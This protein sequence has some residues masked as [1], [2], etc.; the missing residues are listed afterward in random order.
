MDRAAE[1]GSQG[2]TAEADQQF[3]AMR[4][5]TAAMAEGGSS[6][7]ER[8]EPVLAVGQEY[9][10]LPDGYV[11]TISD[12]Q[13][14]VVAK[15]ESD[16][17]IPVGL[18]TPLSDT[19]C[20][21]T[22][23]HGLYVITDTS[24][25]AG[26]DPMY[27]RLPIQAYAGAP[28]NPDGPKRGTVCFVNNN[29]PIA[30]FSEW[31]ETL[32]EH[33]TQWVESEIDRYHATEQVERSQRLLEATFNSPET[34]IGILEPDGT[35]TD[36]NTAAREF[37]HADNGDFTGDLVWETPWWDHDEAMATRCKDAIAQAAVGKRAQFESTH[38]G[39]D[40][41][42]IRTTV[43][44]RPVTS[45]GSVE[46]LIIEAADIT[47]LKRHEE[48]IEFFNSVLRH[49]ILNGMTVVEGRAEL[50][51]ESLTDKNAA[52]AETILDWSHSISRL[53]QKIRRILRI[54][55]D[56]EPVQTTAT[57]LNSLV[58]KSVEKITAA[59][60]DCT[61]QVNMHEHTEVL[62]DPLLGDIVEN[63]FMNAIEHGGPG[64]HIEVE[65]ELTDSSIQLHVAD[66]GPGI[67]PEDRQAIFEK[68]EHRAQSQG[69]GFGLYFVSVMI[70]SYGGSIW[71]EE[72][73]LGGCEFILEFQ[74]A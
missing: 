52:H 70:E 51:S 23:T 11:T 34:Y 54:I 21:H 57:E 20:K 63:I 27:G 49:N 19:Y 6:F 67:P 37:M 64:P 29:E 22:L 25:L 60:H 5:L 65:T 66:D 62:A 73:D 69:T 56:E 12:D 24:E 7:R 44:V 30:A 39:A 46:K 48:Q 2:A 58:N 13:H 10:G 18:T 68:G 16:G 38:V 31:Q 9:L 41:Q 40:D 72:S 61:T 33:I 74:Q 59:D 42:Q 55:G 17:S 71:V 28:L 26:E 4:D 32:L 1:P 14:T 43:T 53:T 50:L 45:D 15:S 36:I 35:V 47:D 3:A 8:V